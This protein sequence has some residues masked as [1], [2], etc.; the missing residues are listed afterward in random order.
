MTD[1][2]GLCW[3]LFGCITARMV[4]YTNID[5]DTGSSGILEGAYSTRTGKGRTWSYQCFGR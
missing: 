5:V 1:C 3:I 2:S 4:F